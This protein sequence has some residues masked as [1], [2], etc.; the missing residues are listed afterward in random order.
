MK[1]EVLILGILIVISAILGCTSNAQSGKQS[2]NSINFQ[3]P[4]GWEL[5]PMPGDGTVIWLGDDPR[6]RV[7]EIKDKRKFDSKY[8]H[9]LNIDKTGYMV[10]TENK[11][12]DNIKV[13]VFKTID[14]R[15][16]DI[17]DEY[18]FQK[19]SKYYYIMAWAYPGWNSA[20]QNK[21]RQEISKAVDI[22][23]KTIQ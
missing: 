7:I 5:H 17:Q 1:V 19:N 23:V 6:I 10:K 18:F 20:K 21:Y 14:N 3:I 9:A 4:E 16:G 13:E 22:I 12:I 11:T 8:N 15:Y 2:G